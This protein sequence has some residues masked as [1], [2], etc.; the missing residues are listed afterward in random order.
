M[1]ALL[2]LVSLLLPALAAAGVIAPRQDEGRPY[3]LGDGDYEVLD[4]T[5]ESI[6][7]PSWYLFDPIFTVVN[8]T[9][10]TDPVDTPM[11]GDYRFTVLNVGLNHTTTCQITN[12]WLT[13]DKFG[14]DGEWHKCNDNTT[15]FQ[16]T[17]KT[18]HTALR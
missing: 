9:E 13:P 7:R 1:L 11:F 14:A 6:T 16:F 18:Y 8:F 10:G 12:V 4:C 3:S 5:F 17:L 2:P 15:E